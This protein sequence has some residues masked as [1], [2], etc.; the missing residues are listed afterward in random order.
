MF[1]ILL[2][3]LLALLFL[4]AELVLLPGLSVAGVLS[5]ICGGSA[6]YRAF[7]DFGW[8]T[9]VV[10]MLVVLALALVTVVV[11]LRAKTWQ[12]F[13]LK[14][15]VGSSA[16]EPVDRE[17]QVGARGR[18]LS[19]LSPMGTVDIGGKIFEAKL[20]SGYADPHT[21]VEVV[22]FENTSVIVKIIK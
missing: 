20:L 15:R 8:K 10:V 7:T 13:A 11:S 6:I 22:G 4:V 3:I 9:G 12:R 14:Q 1:V 21:E 17:V 5:L 16:G 18:T 19:R 2:L